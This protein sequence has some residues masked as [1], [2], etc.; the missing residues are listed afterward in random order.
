MPTIKTNKTPDSTTAIAQALEAFGTIALATDRGTAGVISAYLVSGQAVQHVYETVATLSG[1]RPM[2][3]VNSDLT[4]GIVAKRLPW[5]GDGV[6]R[7]C[8]G[9]P[10]STVQ[11]AWTI[12]HFYRKDSIDVP[13]WHAMCDLV[14]ALPGD[15]NRSTREDSAYKRT[16][17]TG[18]VRWA[19]AMGESN[20][21]SDYSIGAS[22]RSTGAAGTRQAAKI[23]REALV[24]ERVRRIR[25][26]RSSALIV[27]RITADML[28]DLTDDDRRTLRDIL[29]TL[30][31]VEDV[32][33]TLASDAV[34]DNTKGAAKRTRKA[35]AA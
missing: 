12:A 7:T 1:D 32:P 2:D 23:E 4:W 15:E 30:A 14:S 33:A 19:R 21:Q 13:A 10:E 28:R 8:F 18:F 3:L 24:S 6:T 29:A 25:D 34:A 26:K 22:E 31:K 9:R 35:A 20:V 17:L 16:S 27:G 5:D 11:R